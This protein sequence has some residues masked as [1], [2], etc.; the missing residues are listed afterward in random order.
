MWDGLAHSKEARI[1]GFCLMHANS[2]PESLTSPNTSLQNFHSY[3][4]AVILLARKYHSNHT[5]FLWS[6]LLGGVGDSKITV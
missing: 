2:F 5:E 3:T 6:T 1:C 4:G